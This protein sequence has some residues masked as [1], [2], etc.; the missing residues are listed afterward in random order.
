MDCVLGFVNNL[1]LE[2]S[3]WEEK[4]LKKR[5]VNFFHDGSFLV[6]NE[7]EKWIKHFLSDQSGKKMIV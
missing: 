3:K 2:A 1:R 7:I 4:D 6:L 5:N